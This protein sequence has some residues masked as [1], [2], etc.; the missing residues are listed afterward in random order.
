MV[1]PDETGCVGATHSCL[2]EKL[3]SSRNM[4]GSVTISRTS[5]EQVM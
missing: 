1:L 4:D 3:I 5:D 2:A